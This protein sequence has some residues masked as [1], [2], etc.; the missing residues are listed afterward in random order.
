[1]PIAPSVR[2]LPPVLLISRVWVLITPTTVALKV[3]VEADKLS[4]ERAPAAAACV[5]VSTW[6]SIVIV[7]LRAVDEEFKAAL[8]VNGAL[9]LPLE[10]DTV[11][12]PLPPPPTVAVQP[13]V[14]GSTRV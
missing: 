4:W 9:P 2:L 10:G 13:V 12:Q 3:R 7:P 11:S 8:T 6:P 1:M 5:T 14:D